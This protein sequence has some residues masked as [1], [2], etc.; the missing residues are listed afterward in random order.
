MPTA[1]KPHAAHV[2][3]AGLLWSD[4][5]SAPPTP[6]CGGRVSRLAGLCRSRAN[7]RSGSPRQPRP[8]HRAIRTAEARGKAPGRRRQGRHCRRAHAA[9]VGTDRGPVLRNPDGRVDDPLRRPRLRLRAGAR[10]CAPA[11]R[12]QAV[13]ARGRDRPSIA[14]R[15][16]GAGRGPCLARNIA[17]LA[18]RPAHRTADPDRAQPH[19]RNDRPAARRSGRHIAGRTPA[20]H[21]RDRP[22]LLARLGQEAGRLGGRAGPVGRTQEPDHRRVGM[23]HRGAASPERG[24]CLR[25]AGSRAQGPGTRSLLRRP[26]RAGTRDDRPRPAAGRAHRH[27]LPEQQPQGHARPAHCLCT[28]AGREPPL[29]RRDRAT[30]GAHRRTARAGRTLAAARQ[31]AD[32]GQAGCRRRGLAQALHRTLGQPEQGRGRCGGPSPQRVA[33]VLRAVAAGRAPQGFR[34]SRALAVAR[35]RHG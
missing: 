22:Q 19:Q 20:A 6:P 31:P 2:Q 14:F 12:R 10:R 3:K 11:A 16:R 7:Q 25:R 9:A 29:P 24:R 4:E 26:G 30:P 1:T 18:R 34:G 21:G 35:D 15:R 23:G 17:H 27:P 13:P 33:G 5:P 32:A 8:R 28:R